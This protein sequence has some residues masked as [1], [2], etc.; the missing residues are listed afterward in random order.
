MRGTH[1]NPRAP[2]NPPLPTHDTAGRLIDVRIRNMLPVGTVEVRRPVLYWYI[3]VDNNQKTVMIPG[4]D[5]IN[6][7]V[8]GH[9]Y[10]FDDI[11]PTHDW[12]GNPLS[13]DIIQRL[14]FGARDIRIDGPIIR[15]VSYRDINGD[16][17]AIAL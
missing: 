5:Y 13:A 4:L 6:G 15:H 3:A 9:V 14:P 1:Q 10:T 7:Y 16:R 8:E 11:W 17:N 2:V 12:L